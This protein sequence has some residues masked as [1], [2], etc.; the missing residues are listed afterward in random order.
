MERH[1]KRAHKLRPKL[2]EKNKNQAKE[3]DQT[4]TYQEQDTYLI[5]NEEKA[6][7][8]ADV[9]QMQFSINNFETRKQKEK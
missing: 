5:V 9:L 8:V 2:M 6:E 3:E 1:T 7:K 4:S